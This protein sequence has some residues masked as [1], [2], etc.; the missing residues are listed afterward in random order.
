[1]DHIEPLGSPFVWSRT[2]SHDQSAWTEEEQSK[3]KTAMPA[4][5]GEATTFHLPE[6]QFKEASPTAASW[7]SKSQNT[8]Q[9]PRM[10]DC[11]WSLSAVFG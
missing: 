11:S 8:G 1:M 9:A 4:A 6:T 2:A 3:V 10:A 5:A 7:L